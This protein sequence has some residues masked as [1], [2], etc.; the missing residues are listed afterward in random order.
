[1]RGSQMVEKPSYK[2]SDSM[3]VDESMQVLQEDRTPIMV[4]EHIMDIQEIKLMAQGHQSR[5][6]MENFDIIKPS[7]II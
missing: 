4:R 1:M 3:I 2:N 6:S 5:V 7:N